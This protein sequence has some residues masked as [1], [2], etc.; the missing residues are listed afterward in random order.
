MD[1]IAQLEAVVAQYDLNTH[2]FY[3]DWRMGTLP[4]PK[5]T[6]YAGEY[7]QFV[8]TI[9]SGW[10]TLG[11]DHYAEEEREHEVLWGDFR[12][13]VGN[14]AAT[15]RAQ[16]AVLVNTANAM[17]SAGKPEAAGA[18]FAFERQQ[19]LTSQSKLDGLNEHYSLTN[20][21]KEYFVVHAGDWNEVEDLKPVLNA[22]SDA[23][24]ERAKSA[25]TLVCTAMWAGLDG[26]YYN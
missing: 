13:E 6:D 8:G 2:P 17:F 16:T 22:M 20:A 24:F 11:F 18:L 14:E 10:E 12:K 3:Q 25:C 4:M 5:L 21:G 9:A 26:I 23:E 1:R 15:N 7:G 19:P